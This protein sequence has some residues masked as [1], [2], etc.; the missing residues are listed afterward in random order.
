MSR[1]HPSERIAKKLKSESSSIAT[2]LATTITVPDDQIGVVYSLHASI[3]VGGEA[4]LEN[5]AAIET[6][7]IQIGGTNVWLVD[8]HPLIAHDDGTNFF[9]HVDLG[10]WSWYWPPDG[11]YSGVKGEN[12]IITF[13]SFGTGIVSRMNFQYSGD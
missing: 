10:P 5:L 6:L 9:R 13:P 4:D 8:V 1:L 2:I 12:I 11:L 3:D 7:Q